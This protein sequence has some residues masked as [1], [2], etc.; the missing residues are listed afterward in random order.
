MRIFVDTNVLLDIIIPREDS[1]LK[2]TSGLFLS[3]RDQK[4]YEL[5]VS[6][7]SMATCAFYLKDNKESVSKMRILT[8]GLTI[9]DTLACDFS[10]ALSYEQK[11]IEDAIQFSVASRY[12]CDLIATRDKHGFRKSPVPFMTPNMILSKILPLTD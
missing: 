1:T 2:I 12:K 10:S 7:V 6:T 9:L 4:D 3:L 5:C 8:K 11:D